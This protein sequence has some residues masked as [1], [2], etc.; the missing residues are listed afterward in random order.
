[1]NKKMNLSKLK[2]N[3]FITKLDVKNSETVK[4]GVTTTAPLTLFGCCD[5]KC[6][7]EPLSTCCKVNH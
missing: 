1:M 2:V 5:D 3:S 4:G 6:H 7:L